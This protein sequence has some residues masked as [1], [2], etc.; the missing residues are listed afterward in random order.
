M[1]EL[2]SW[3]ASALQVDNSEAVLIT[4]SVDMNWNLADN[5]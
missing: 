1:A 3:F 2:T 5:E 4:F